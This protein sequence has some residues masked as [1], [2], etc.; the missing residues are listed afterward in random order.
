MA[1]REGLY[2]IESKENGATIGRNSIEDKSALP[3]R[4]V[5][6]SVG[7]GLLPS[8]RVREICGSF[9]ID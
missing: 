1:L 9:S 5:I 7:D 2:I 3:K 4:V 6:H 8:V